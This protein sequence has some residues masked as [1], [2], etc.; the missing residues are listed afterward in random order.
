LLIC[1]GFFCAFHHVADNA[2]GADIEGQMP[3][4]AVLDDMED[5][6]GPVQFNHSMHTYIAENC[7]QCHHQHGVNDTTQ[8]QGCHS[9]D[10]P[11]LKK[12]AANGFLGCKTCHD[13]LNPETPEMPGLKVAYHKQCFKCHLGMGGLGEGPQGCTT[14]CHARKER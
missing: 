13:K 12:V 3:D 1:T 5:Q 6:Y 11:A 4:I 7:G 14:Q 8:C 10:S 2:E 9:F